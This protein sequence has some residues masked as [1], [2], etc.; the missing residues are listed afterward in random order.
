LGLALPALAQSDSIADLISV[1]FQNDANFGFGPER[2][3]LDPVRPDH[4]GPIGQLP[5]RVTF[6][7]PSF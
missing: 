4:V 3:T 2:G 6:V 7:L 5:S 1:P